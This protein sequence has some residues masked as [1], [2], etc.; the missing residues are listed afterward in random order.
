MEKVK[1]RGAGRRDTGSLRPADS[2]GGSTRA[3]LIMPRTL[4]DVAH[5]A[6][7]SRTLACEAA[8]QLSPQRPPRRSK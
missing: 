2:D 4:E 5:G 1:R 7:A 8:A 3:T 6:D